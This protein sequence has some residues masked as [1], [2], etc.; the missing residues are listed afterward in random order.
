MPWAVSTYP[1]RCAR[2]ARWC[3]LF[4]TTHSSREQVV[5]EKTRR[6]PARSVRSSQA[7]P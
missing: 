6:G 5:V 2:I 4:G 7:I 3:G 1:S